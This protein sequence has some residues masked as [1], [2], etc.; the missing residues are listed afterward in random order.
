MSTFPKTGEQIQ[1]RQGS[2]AINVTVLTAFPEAQ[3]IVGRM[4]GIPAKSEDP[5]GSFIV[6]QLQ[7]GRWMFKHS[8][9]P[10]QAGQPALT[11]AQKAAMATAPPPEQ[12]PSAQ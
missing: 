6:A 4:I 11:A 5:R 2:R 1:V 12:Q 3:E 10:E 9:T 8:L 7:F